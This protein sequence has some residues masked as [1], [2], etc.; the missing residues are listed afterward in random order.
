MYTPEQSQRILELRQKVLQNQATPEELKEGLA[1]LR[2]SRE[3]AHAA[4]A[5]SR[6]AR[7]S[8]AAK[9]NINSDSLLDELGGL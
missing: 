3:G 2:R 7:A 1:L 5:T 8:T 9:K 4:S 6:S